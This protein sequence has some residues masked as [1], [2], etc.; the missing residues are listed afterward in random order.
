MVGHEMIFQPEATFAGGLGESEKRHSGRESQHRIGDDS[1]C[2]DSLSSVRA[3]E[4]RWRRACDS[5]SVRHE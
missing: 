1:H 2:L 3:S 5:M 4:D